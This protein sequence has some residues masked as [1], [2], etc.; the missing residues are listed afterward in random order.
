MRYQRITVEEA[1]ANNIPDW[2]MEELLGHGTYTAKSRFNGGDPEVKSP[3][4][5]G[6]DVSKLGSVEDRMRT[7]D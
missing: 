4:D 2:L 3:E 7:K 5:R 6:V 1:P